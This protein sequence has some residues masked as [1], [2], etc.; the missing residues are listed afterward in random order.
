M[1]GNRKIIEKIPAQKGAYLLLLFVPQLTGKIQIGK[2]GIYRFKRGW[3]LYVGSAQGPGGLRARIR[4]HL[5]INSTP[6]WHL[7]YF[8][9]FAFP[10]IIAW[11]VSP[12]GMESK[13]AS[14]LSGLCDD[15]PVK[16]FGASDSKAK[17]HL[18]YF[19]NLKNAQKAIGQL[20][21]RHSCIIQHL[22]V[23]R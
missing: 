11:L 1:N 2:L 13:L 10:R 20:E 15:I 5:G 17:S 9:P 16:N 21:E 19:R 7:D 12:P 23:R 4:H 8:R 14:V 6:H 18:F 3:Y 22:N